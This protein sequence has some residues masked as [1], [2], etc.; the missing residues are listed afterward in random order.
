MFLV[1][2]AHMIIANKIAPTV[3]HRR[4]IMLIFVD[5]TLS[6][7]VLAR[8]DAEF[9]ISTL[10][11]LITSSSAGL[12]WVRVNSAAPI[13]SPAFNRAIISSATP[14]HCVRVFSNFVT[15]SLS[16]IFSLC[17]SSRFAFIVAS[18]SSIACSLDA[19]VCPAIIISRTSFAAINVAIR[20]LLTASSAAT[21]PSINSSRLLFAF[22]SCK[23]EKIETMT[24][25]ISTIPNDTNN[26]V[27]IF[28]FF[29]FFLSFCF[30]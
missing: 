18:F 12:H 14:I 17:I 15:S 22:L 2:L 21:A 23:I 29:N 16:R 8:I 26:L 20:Q 25:N 10:I 30:I 3:I 24:V 4:T 19:S 28:K 1:T 5:F 9:S 11:S 6:L 27:L 7:S 13:A